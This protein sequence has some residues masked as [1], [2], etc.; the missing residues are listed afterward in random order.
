MHTHGPYFWSGI[1]Y[2]Q[3]G[4]SDLENGANTLWYPDT[5]INMC[6][7]LEW[8]PDETRVFVKPQDGLLILF[9]GWLPHDA[10]P[11]IGKDDRICVAFNS[12]LRSETS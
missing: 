9:P 6:L 12:I 10:R 7:G 3:S 11:Y 4:Q 1:F 2:V 5:K 8:A